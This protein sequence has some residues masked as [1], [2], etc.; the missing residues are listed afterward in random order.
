M[1]PRL[2]AVDDPLVKCGLARGLVG[3][4]MRPRLIAVDDHAPDTPA[5]DARAG[6]HEATAYCRG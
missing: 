4:S 1:R 3:A 2:I 6:F 5:G